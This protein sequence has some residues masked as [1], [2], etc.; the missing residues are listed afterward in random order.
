MGICMYIGLYIYIAFNEIAA[1]IWENCRVM[2]HLNTKAIIFK[3]NTQTY[4]HTYAQLCARK[5]KALIFQYE[6]RKY[7]NINCPWAVSSLHKIFHLKSLW[8]FVLTFTLKRYST[9]GLRANTTA[10]V[11][12]CARSK[13]LSL[14][15]K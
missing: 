15:N 14:N 8:L 12:T 7:M 2:R 9:E 4:I 3:K 13:Q 1:L 6:I 5:W 11:H 10:N